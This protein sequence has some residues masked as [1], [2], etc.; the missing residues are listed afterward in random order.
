MS[1]DMIAI[2]NGNEG[3]CGV[4][5]EMLGRQPDECGAE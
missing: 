1:D 4:G 3:A 2:E 5:V